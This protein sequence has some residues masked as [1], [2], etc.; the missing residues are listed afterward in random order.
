VHTVPPRHPP[1]EKLALLRRRKDVAAR[2]LRGEQQLE[3]AAAIGIDQSNVSR[4]LRW[5]H[6]QWLEESKLANAE[7]VARELARID[8]VERE[9]WQAWQRSQQIAESTRTQ[10]TTEPDGTGGKL[11]AEVTRRGSA[12]DSCYLETV[13]KCVERR[14]KLLGLEK[15]PPPTLVMPI[16][17]DLVTAP[18]DHDEIEVRL[19]AALER[20]A[21]PALEDT[22][23]PADGNGQS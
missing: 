5:V 14:S 20:Q 12:G 10:K 1:P 17:W 16:P 8:L 15:A 23:R 21:A 9:A 6:E 7:R 11:M 13:L 22:S 4:D 2:Y 19:A 3:I 18:P